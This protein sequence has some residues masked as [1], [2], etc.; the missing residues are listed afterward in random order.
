MGKKGSGESKRAITSE[1]EGT[2]FVVKL[3]TQVRAQEIREMVVS[4]GGTA[5]VYRGEGSYNPVKA[6]QKREVERA[7]M[8]SA[9]AAMRGNNSEA[10]ELKAKAQQLATAYGSDLTK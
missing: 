1:F 3:P 5:F 9:K 2:T 8:D 6:G 4:L 10:D 7:L